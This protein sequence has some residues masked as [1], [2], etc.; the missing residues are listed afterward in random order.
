MYVKISIVFPLWL[1]LLAPALWSQS[2]ILDQYVKT[3]LENN[4]ALK[5]QNL[6][7]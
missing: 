3:G 1:L 2:A 4:Q 5:T 6:S 7:Y